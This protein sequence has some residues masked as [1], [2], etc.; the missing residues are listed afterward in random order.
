MKKQNLILLMGSLL[1]LNSA[2]TFGQEPIDSN[3]QENDY[4][5]VL[6]VTFN[7]KTFRDFATSPLFYN[8]VGSDF[9][10]GWLRRS[11]AS[12][13]MFDIGLGVNTFFARVPTSDFLQSGSTAFMLQLNSTYSQLFE[14]G[15]ISTDKNNIKVGGLIHLTQN[16]RSNFGLFNNGLGL[17]NSIN[18][19]ASGQLIR[20]ISR[21]NPREVNLLLFK[22][23][24][25]PV[26]RDLR[27]QLNAGLLNLNNRPGYAY[28]SQ[29]E[30]IG[31]ETHPITWLLSNYQTSLNGWR[32][33]SE[34]E[35]I[36]YLP[37]GNARSWS[38]VWDAIHMP[39]RYESFQMAS[40]QIRYRI[41]F[42][43]KKR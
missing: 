9:Q 16:I 38:Y 28:S 3:P 36:K 31:L 32:Y 22:P 41:F 37:N 11:K 40:H 35:L 8:G 29:S 19:M 6:G 5:S 24:L 4:Y 27:F 25:K 39:G 2:L 10:A 43:T 26:K 30:I 33:T 34:I 18:I 1:L 21:V 7:R 12:E 17:E 15:K 14:I 13:R 42:H 20:D 23:T